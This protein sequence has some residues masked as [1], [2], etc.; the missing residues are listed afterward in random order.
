MSA[1]SD[2]DAAADPQRLITSLE[3]SA[4][5]LASMKHY[6]AVAQLRHVAGSRAG[7]VLDIGCG[8]GHDIAALAH[9]GIDNVVGVDLS[10]V[11][12]ETA[13]ARS[14]TPVARATGTRLPFRDRSFAGCWIERVLMHVDDPETVLAEAVRCL[15]PGGV[16][17]IFEPDWSSLTVNGWRVPASWATAARHPAIGSE[18]GSML[19]RLGCFVC[20]RVEERSFWTFAQF[21]ALLVNGALSRAAVKSDPAVQLWLEDVRASA[22]RGSFH[23]ELVKVAWIATTPPA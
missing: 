23:A 19:Q 3:Q 20:D 16:M 15:T 17:T 12:V 13:R 9:H 18:V 4:Q 21:D 2:V 22:A 8:A 11:M 6:M 10:M 14:D 1:F 5:G 7:W